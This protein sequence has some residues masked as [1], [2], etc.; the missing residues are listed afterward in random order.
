MPTVLAL[1]PA[2]ILEPCVPPN[3]E[4]VVVVAAEAFPNKPV[5]GAEV[6]AMLPNMLG[7]DVVAAD[8]P[9]LGTPDCAPKIEED[10]V[11]VAIDC[12]APKAL[13]VTADCGAPKA[14][15]VAPDCG[16]PKALEVAADCGA[17]K[18]LVVLGD[19]NIGFAVVVDE[20]LLKRLGAVV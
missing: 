18:A 1:A 20:A 15:D 19:L 5:L 9:K 2:K 14:L 13:D 6:D 4:G 11:V 17:P 12:G 7:T 10:A 8:A 16:A 3:A